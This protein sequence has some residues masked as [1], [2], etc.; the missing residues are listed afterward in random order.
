MV[1]VDEDSMG[2]VDTGLWIPDAGMEV[3]N[4]TVVCTISDAVSTDI[5]DVTDGVTVSAIAAFCVDK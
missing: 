3:A 1:V 5:A 2:L 4:G